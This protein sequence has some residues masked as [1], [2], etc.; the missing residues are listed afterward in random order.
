MLRKMAALVAALSCSMVV[1]SGDVS[2]RTDE[3][4]KEPCKIKIIG[5]TAAEEKLIRATLEKMESQYTNIFPYIKVYADNKTRHFAP[6]RSAHCDDLDQHLCLLR[7]AFYSSDIR[8]EAG[9]A[10]EFK[11]R[12]KNPEFA[13]KWQKIAGEVYG[14]ALK[15]AKQFPVCGILTRYGSQNYKEDWAE[16]IESIFGYIND[17]PNLF[18]PPVDPR[19]SRYLA[20]PNL[21]LECGAISKETHKKIIDLLKP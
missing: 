9:H 16:W 17:E 21:L 8:H 2:K 14:D 13:L 12:T 3:N 11:L 5:A 1:A 6:G 7:N 20:K 10:Y 15:N 4:K 18:A 19:D